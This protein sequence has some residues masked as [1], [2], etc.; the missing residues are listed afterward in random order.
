[1]PGL[2]PIIGAT[3]FLFGTAFL[4]FAHGN[5]WTRLLSILSLVTLVALSI[6]WGGD[7]TPQTTAL[8]LLILLVLFS[9][10]AWGHLIYRNLSG[11]YENLTK[12]V[13]TIIVV[14]ILILVLLIV[15]S[16]SL[17]RT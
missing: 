16:F 8:V 15:L 10:S 13:T 2:L 17:F 4:S 12:P 1:M 6:P 11:Q 3:I 14:V 9:L 7:Y 5:I